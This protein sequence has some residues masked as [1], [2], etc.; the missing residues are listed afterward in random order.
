MVEV[1]AERS[2]SGPDGAPR[3]VHI[4]LRQQHG[5]PRPTLA[6]ETA[7]LRLELRQ[8]QTL[9]GELRDLEAD[10]VAGA[11]VAVAGIA[12]PD[13][14]P[15]RLPPASAAE[16]PHSEPSASSAAS[17]SAGGASSPSAGSAPSSSSPSSPTSSISSSIS[18]SSTSVGTTT[19]AMIVSSG[20]SRNS[21]PSGAVTSE[22][23]I[24]AAISMPETSTAM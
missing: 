3:L 10:V 1:H 4:G 20:S 7:V 18:G 15:V 21:T 17:P 8:T 11:R 13:H 6:V 9:G 19:V 12:Q 23:C 16:D 2:A 24:V 14:Q 22:R 5:H